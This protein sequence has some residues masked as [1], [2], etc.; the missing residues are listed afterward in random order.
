MFWGAVL[1]LGIL[2]ILIFAPEVWYELSTPGPVVAPIPVPTFTPTPTGTPAPLPRSSRPEAIVYTAYAVVRHVVHAEPDNILVK[3]VEA[4]WKQ[5]ASRSPGPL[6]LTQDAREALTAYFHSPPRPGAAVY[7]VSGAV[8]LARRLRADKSAWGVIAFDRLIPALYPMKV[9]GKDILRPDLTLRDLDDYPF[10]RHHIVANTWPHSNHERD[11]FG[12]LWVT[13]ATSLTGLWQQADETKIRAGLETLQRR[14]RGSTWVHTQMDAPVLSRCP[15]A[16]K[17][18]T[19]VSPRR[20]K[21]LHQL[22]VNLVSLA[23]PNMARFGTGGALFSVQALEKE[24]IRPLGVGRVTPE[25]IGFTWSVGRGRVA[26]ISLGVPD[27]SSGPWATPS[28]EGVLAYF[29][30]KDR[31]ILDTLAKVTRHNKSVVVFMRW[32]QV[33]DLAGKEQV[34]AFERLRRN[35]ATVV[36]GVQ[37]GVVQRLNYSTDGLVA[38]G[39][40]SFLHDASTLSVALRLVLYDGRLIAAQPFFL[41]RDGLAWHVI[42]GEEADLLWSRFVR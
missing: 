27:N 6:Y 9:D 38:Y 30:G 41:Q 18:E 4:R 22:G 16:S 36:I 12:I 3:D 10:T 29:P 42:R 24:G 33:R 32:H 37:P 19:C 31:A 26:L 25:D 39:L 21:L 5:P 40:G 13:G 8:D 1:F 34:R 7:A 14:F 35:G 2:L 23:G 15:T 20:I 17:A 28:R 11:R